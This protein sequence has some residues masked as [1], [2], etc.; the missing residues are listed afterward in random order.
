[1]NGHSGHRDAHTTPWTCLP[2]PPF[3]PSS[4]PRPPPPPLVADT[5]YGEFLGY[6]GKNDD[7]DD[8]DATVVDAAADD[9]TADAD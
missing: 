3:P 6:R 1:M 5:F 4:P 7:G 8:A 9:D 2:L